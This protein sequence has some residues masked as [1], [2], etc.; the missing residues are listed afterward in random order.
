MRSGSGTQVFL[1]CGHGSGRVIR[2]SVR[3]D[4][5]HPRSWTILPPYVPA[6]I[7][8]LSSV[9]TTA[10]QLY[11]SLNE[12]LD[13]RRAMRDF[14]FNIDQFDFGTNATPKASRE[15]QQLRGRYLH[16]LIRSPP[17]LYQLPPL[18]MKDGGDRRQETGDGRR[19]KGEGGG[20][21]LLA[22][23]MFDALCSFM[24]HCMYKCCTVPYRT[25]V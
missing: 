22:A 20:R 10:V 13:A 8:C 17:Y 19:E 24:V 11:H 6:I 23:I 2:L 14:C 7:S 25:L 4:A 16:T 3:D 5:L 12:Y 1:T 15:D 21:R 18:W 9:L